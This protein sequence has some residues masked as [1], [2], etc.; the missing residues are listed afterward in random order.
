VDTERG[1]LEQLFGLA[2]VTITTASAAGALEIKGL[3]RDVAERLV[4][5]LTAATREEREDAT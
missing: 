3:D 2:S 4:D 5:E 1:P